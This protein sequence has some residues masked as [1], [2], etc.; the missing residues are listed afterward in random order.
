MTKKK[1]KW[2]EKQ[3]ALRGQNMHLH[4]LTR[5][6]KTAYNA[7]EEVD[8]YYKVI[9]NHSEMRNEF[10]VMVGDQVMET[11]FDSGK[12]RQMISD[13]VDRRVKNG[14]MILKSPI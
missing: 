3:P 9:F 14:W 13:I 5:H 1:E 2:K 8:V 6:N 12:A 11:F 7:T 10:R 4:K